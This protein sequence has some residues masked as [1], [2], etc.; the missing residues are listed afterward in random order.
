MNLKCGKD[1]FFEKEFYASIKRMED[2]PE[3]P[4][5]LFLFFFWFKRSYIQTYGTVL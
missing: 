4:K 5:I 3:I 1:A 2:D